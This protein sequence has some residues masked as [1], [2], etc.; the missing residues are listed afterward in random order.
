[1]FVTRLIRQLARQE[2][3]PEDLDNENGVDA[4]GAIAEA[5]IT[6]K[7]TSSDVAITG[8]IDHVWRD[9]YDA[10]MRAL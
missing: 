9:V 5:I 10:V 1:M 4:I 8:V 7:T 6:A 3:V 2:L